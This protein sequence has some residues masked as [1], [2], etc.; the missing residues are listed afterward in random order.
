MNRWKL[1][2]LRSTRCS[3]KLITRRARGIAFTLGTLSRARTKTAL[4]KSNKLYGS[5]FYSSMG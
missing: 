1:V 4:V 3:D 2:E 5:T